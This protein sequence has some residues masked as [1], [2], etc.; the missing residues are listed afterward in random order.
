MKRTIMF[1]ILAFFLLFVTACGQKGPL[2]LPN[3]AP[4]QEGE[5]EGV[6]AEGPISVNPG[7][8]AQSLDRE[9]D[10]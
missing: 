4:V 7:S 1:T 9:R 3:E 2:Y 8:Q 5:A 10:S 6:Q